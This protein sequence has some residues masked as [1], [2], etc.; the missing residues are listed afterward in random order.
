M[1]A[2]L[3]DP[4][5]FLDRR[6]WERMKIVVI[7]EETPHLDPEGTDVFG[8]DGD[9]F[10]FGYVFLNWDGPAEERFG[11]L[12]INPGCQIS[13]FSIKYCKLGHQDL[14]RIYD[15]P[16][17]PDR[18]AD[19]VDILGWADIVVGWNIGFD[20]GWLQKGMRRHG[21]APLKLPIVIDL[22]SVVRHLFP[23]WRSHSLKAAFGELLLS[24]PEADMAVIPSGSKALFDCLEVKAI[25]ERLASSPRMTQHLGELLML[26]EHAT[27]LQNRDQELWG[28]MFRTDPQDGKIRWMGN[29]DAGHALKDSQ[30]GY[31]EDCL[32]GL[33]SFK[34][35][36]WSNHP[37]MARAL[38]EA[39]LRSRR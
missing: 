16:R 9:P 30:T 14:T 7:D 17:F 13:D 2:G 1:Q 39:E 6:L 3:Y 15:A 36:R 23:R 29:K 5:L 12:W 34:G 21:G 32:N 11:Q 10:E 27:T 25:L 35:I 37:P 24:I 38:V 22:M 20:L 28:G 4:R 8:V 26:H 19:I 31:L 33:K 18:V